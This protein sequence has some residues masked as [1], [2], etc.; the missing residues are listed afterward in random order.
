[1]CGSN[2]FKSSQIKYFIPF[3]GKRWCRTGIT[4][5][6]GHNIYVYKRVT[7]LVLNSVQAKLKPRP[8]FKRSITLLMKM[9]SKNTN[10]LVHKEGI[11]CVNR[12]LLSST[13]GQKSRRKKLKP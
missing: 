11:I 2:V 4:N 7:V 6:Q 5:K 1:M 12:T 13:E 10:T 8:L 9:H 3:K